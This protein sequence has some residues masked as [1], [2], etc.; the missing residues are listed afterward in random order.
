MPSCRKQSNATCTGFHGSISHQ[1]PLLQSY[2]AQQLTLISD[3]ITSTASG[4]RCGLFLFLR[5]FWCSMVCLCVCLCVGHVGESS[6]NGWTDQD[7]ARLN[8]GTYTWV[9][10]V[11]TIVMARKFLIKYNSWRC[12]LMINA[13]IMMHLELNTMYIMFQQVLPKVIWEKHVATRPRN[14]SSRDD[15]ST[16]E[17][18]HRLTRSASHRLVDS[19]E[20]RSIGRLGLQHRSVDFSDFCYAQQT[21]S[22][23]SSC[24]N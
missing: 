19:I 13:D 15:R 16:C 11:N 2:T 6:K 1:L 5:M 12:Q 10:L 3:H 7:V 18:M 4:A 8:G 9:L 17:K 21:A 24:K 20:S 14:Q 22:T 23:H